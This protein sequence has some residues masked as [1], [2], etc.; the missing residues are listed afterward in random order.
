MT[1]TYICEECGKEIELICPMSEMKRTI[2]CPHCSKTAYKKIEMPSLVGV[3]S[4]KMKIKKEM[5]KRNIEA[6]KRMIGSHKSVRAKTN[7]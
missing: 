1:Y 6:G 5:T 3:S 4:S 7:E 2:K